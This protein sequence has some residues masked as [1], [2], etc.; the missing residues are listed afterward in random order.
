MKKAF[1]FA[2]AAL[3]AAAPVMAQS[4]PMIAPAEGEGLSDTGA[5][6]VAAAF[7]AGIVAIAVVGASSD[8][9]LPVSA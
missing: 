3:L 2:S 4:V 9:N 7:I 8:D 6:I 5:G 1:I